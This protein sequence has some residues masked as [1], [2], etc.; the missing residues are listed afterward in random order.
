MY[1]QESIFAKGAVDESDIV[2]EKQSF[3]QYSVLNIYH[4]DPYRLETKISRSSLSFSQCCNWIRFSCR[5]CLR[6]K[7]SLTLA[8]F[9]GIQ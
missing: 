7:L 5:C 1:G 9:I 8:V 6:R 4:F 3:I 2:A